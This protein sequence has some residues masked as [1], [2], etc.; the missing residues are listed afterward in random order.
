MKKNMILWMGALFLTI[1][2]LSSCSS[3]EEGL[4]EITGSYSNGEDSPAGARNVFSDDIN[5]LQIQ[6]ENGDTETCRINPAYCGL[7]SWPVT[8]CTVSNTKIDGIYQDSTY[9]VYPMVFSAVIKNSSAFN[10]LQI[11]YDS[12]E[13][14]RIENLEVGDSLDSS[15]IRFKAWMDSALDGVIRWQNSPWALEGKIEVADKRTDDDGKSYIT[16]SL[17]NLKLDSWA[18][19]CMESNHTFN[20]MI[21]FE[22]SENGI[23]P[24][25]GFD[26]KSLT[27]PSDE[28]N[29]F[30]MDALHSDE[31]QG[32]HTFFS[33]TAKEEK[34]LIINSEEEFRKSYKGDKQL[35]KVNFD[36]CTLVIGRTYG[37]HGGVSLGGFEL[38]D[39]GDTYQ[40]NVTL[41][42]IVNPDYCYTAAFTDLYFW[43]IYLK[44]DNKPVV[45]NRIQQDVNLDPLA[46]ANA[47]I[48]NHW[49]LEAYS[50]ADGTFH[51]L[52]DGRG[53][54]RFYIEFMEDGKAEGRIN[55]TND[56][57][58]NY[59]LKFSGKRA[60]Y[61]DAVDHGVINLSNWQVTDVDDDDPVSK[62]FMHISNASQFKLINTCSL[63]LFLSPKEFLLFRNDI[64]E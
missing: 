3:D 10:V 35:P 8:V 33:E 47:R 13:R 56:F 43:N 29:F 44:M 37:E 59:I 62:R 57:S 19:C 64:Q 41:N 39:D 34:L 30:M 32:R 9:N 38:T 17:Q 4:N 6:S 51:R 63:A 31:L 60:Y 7:I 1:A 52:N 25:D 55:D 23:Y 45:F 61:E 20:G 50:D 46:D 53:D 36:D 26:A 11:D 21:E 22:I 27:I 5:V 24:D 2:G 16:L 40:V 28:L 12:H 42:N 15:V 54:E 48:R 18:S 49:I 14:I 58:C